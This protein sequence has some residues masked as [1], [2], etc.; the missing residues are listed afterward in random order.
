MKRKAK[1]NCANINKRVLFP[2]LIIYL[3]K[4]FDST[5]KVHCYQIYLHYLLITTQTVY[6]I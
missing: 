6:Y 2:F 5:K 1:Y 3:F 4:T